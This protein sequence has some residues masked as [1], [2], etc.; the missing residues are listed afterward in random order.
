MSNEAHRSPPSADHWINS[1][2]SICSPDQ[3]GMILVH[4]GVVRGTSKHG[5]PITRM[6][7]S[8]DPEKLRSLIE[9]Y[10][11]QEGIAEVR[12]WINEGELAVGEEIMC[13]LVAGRFRTDV[14]PVFEALLGAIKNEVVRELE[15][16]PQAPS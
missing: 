4:R 11:Q 13:V 3:V 12:V 15:V 5:D 1:V 6:N 8:H 16:G 10:R 2:K 7:L 9:Y 14:L